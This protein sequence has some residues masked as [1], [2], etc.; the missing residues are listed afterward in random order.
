[1]AKK[2]KSID[3]DAWLEDDICTGETQA[4]PQNAEEAEIQRYL[5]SKVLEKD[6]ALTILEWW[7]LHEPFYPRISKVAKK[8]L[9]VPASSVSSEMYTDCQQEKM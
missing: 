4:N 5:G 1:M 7:K 8:Y 2:I 3:T 9:S 6:H